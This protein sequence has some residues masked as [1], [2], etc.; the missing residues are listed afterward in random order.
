MLDFLEILLD[1]MGM[2]MRLSDDKIEALK[3]LFHQ[4]DQWKACRK[5]ELLSLIGKLSHA[6]KMIRVSISLQ[7]DNYS[8]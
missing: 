5:R 2:E 4:W 6:C 7:D 8:K 3:V 1:I